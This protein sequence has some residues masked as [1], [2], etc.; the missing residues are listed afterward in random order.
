[1]DDT[2]CLRSFL[3]PDDTPHRRHEALRASFVQERPLR[4]SATPFGSTS[5]TLPQV[6]HEFRSQ[7]R[8]GT[9][10]PWFAAPR[11][12]RPDRPPAP[13]PETPPV[14]DRRGRRLEPGRRP[15]SR[16]AGL[17]RFLPLR[18][19]LRF[20]HRVAIAGDPGT[21]LVPA[22]RAVLGLLALTLRGKERRSHI[23]DFNGDEGL[24][25]RA[26]RNVLPKTAL[27]TAYSSRTQRGHRPRLR[28]GGIAAWASRLFPDGRACA[29][30]GHAIPFRGAPAA[31]DNHDL[32]RCGKA[33]PSIL[34]FFAQEQGRRVVC[35]AN[36]N[37]TRADQPG[38][39]R[40]FVA[41]WQEVTG[42]DPQW[43]SFDSQ[44]VPDAERSRLNSR[45]IHVVTIR[46]RGAAVIR[47]LRAPPLGA[48]QHAVIAT[49]RRYHQR[50]RFVDERVRLPG[51]EATIRHRAADGLG[52]EQPTLCLSNDLEETARSL[53]V[54]YA[55]RNGVKNGLGNPGPPP[56]DSDLT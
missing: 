24:G 49:P 53:I 47:R 13:C 5:D 26:G 31:L 38:E 23:R 50:I 45:G 28:S 29:W 9:P 7:C 48:W 36:A 8:A 54:R 42:H 27:A 18:A 20:D 14:A 56:Q 41:F 44:V 22:T 55:G 4:A 32:P 10:P 37:L 33:G 25:L 15:R 1:V 3:P 52:R 46:R 40:R 12:G 19:H 6:I 21:A 30:D 2:L 16:V 39:P 43:L 51:D 17:V 11:H 35:S 34:R